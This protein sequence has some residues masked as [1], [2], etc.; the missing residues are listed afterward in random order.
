MCL[1]VW[2][3]GLLP[4]IYSG[5]AKYGRQSLFRWVKSYCNDL[6]VPLKV[7]LSLWCSPWMILFSANHSL[8]LQCSWRTRRMLLIL[9]GL[10]L[11]PSCG[12]HKSRRE[13]VTD[14]PVQYHIYY[15]TRKNKLM[16]LIL[17]HA[18]NQQ[19]FS[20]L[21]LELIFIATFLDCL[22][23]SLTTIFSYQ[24]ITWSSPMWIL[25]SGRVRFF[26]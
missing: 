9:I 8:Y 17:H 13:L 10:P 22:C 20:F 7:W 25:G 18:N 21:T 23:N 5:M 2:I 16:I 14:C 3:W 24:I 19:C 26:S 6:I 12:L 15:G 1:W 4:L 11:L